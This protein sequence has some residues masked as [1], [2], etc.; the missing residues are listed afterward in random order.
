MMPT[1]EQV[2]TYGYAVL[3]NKVKIGFA[4][5][6][7]KVLE[8]AELLVPG[9]AVVGARNPILG[10]AVCVSLSFLAQGRDGY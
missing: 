4:K 6:V 7:A 2:G 3:R 1:A 9:A 8:D 10:Y 5:M